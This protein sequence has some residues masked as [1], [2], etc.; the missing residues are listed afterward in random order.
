MINTV[1]HAHH[2]NPDGVAGLYMLLIP[3]DID[4]ANLESSVS[5]GLAC[6]IF[7]VFHLHCLKQ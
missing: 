1:S 2:V 4:I 5:A 3:V 6:L 7:Q